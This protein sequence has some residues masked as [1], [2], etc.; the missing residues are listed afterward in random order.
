MF[1]FARRGLGIV[2]IVTS[3]CLFAG[4]ASANLI[5]NGGFESPSIPPNSI[6]HVT[7][8]DWTGCCTIFNGTFIEPG[9]TWPSPEEGNQ[10]VDIG[11][12]VGTS[13]SQTISIITGGNHLLSWF[14][15]T[16]ESGG[17]TGSPYL[18]T[19]V[20]SSL[21]TVISQSFNA[22][23]GSLTWQPKSLDIV[24]SPGSYDLTFF[25]EG[26]PFGLD[27][28]LDNVSLS[29]AV[30]PVPEPSSLALIGGGLLGLVALRRRTA[31][32]A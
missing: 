10:F 22:Y 31:K 4:S 11:N 26:V 6:A 18:V 14:D 3:G 1:T 23:T 27:T 21:H 29:L 15:N 24:L 7:P 19:L 8:T 32:R 5:L 16:G 30:S 2:A 25:A 17:V 28:L 20:D 13:L 9:T 12:A